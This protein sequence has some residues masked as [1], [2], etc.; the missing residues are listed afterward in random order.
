MMPFWG[1]CVA[2]QDAPMES[3]E[4]EDSDKGSANG[5]IGRDVECISFQAGC[6]SSWE[7]CAKE[8][9]EAVLI[10]S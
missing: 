9:P 7:V 2:V 3:L 1:R 6:Q 8:D 4:E 10:F 5:T